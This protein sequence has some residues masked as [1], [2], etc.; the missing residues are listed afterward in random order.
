MT[1]IST[2][3]PQTPL[4]P[5]AQ[6]LLRS[7]RSWDG[8]PYE[9]YPAGPPELTLLQV[10]IPPDTELGWHIHPTPSAA[11]I[12]S[13]EVRVETREGGR[14]TLLKQGDTIAALVNIQHRA[15]TGEV[16]VELLVFYAGIEG[17]P[18]SVSDL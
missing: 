7:T 11:Y 8:T 15:K 2:P 18:L 5:R 14:N 4:Q 3:E 13:G 16:P 1:S 9:R 10:N 6:V 12:L 17:E